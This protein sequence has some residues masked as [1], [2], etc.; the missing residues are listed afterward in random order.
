MRRTLRKTAIL[1]TTALVAGKNGY[2]QN[3]RLKSG[4]KLGARRRGAGELSN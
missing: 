4:R 1:R 3:S 2:G